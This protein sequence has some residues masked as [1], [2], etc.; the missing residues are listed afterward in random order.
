MKTSIGIILEAVPSS[1]SLDLLTKDLQGINGV[2][3]V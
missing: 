2:R 3:W 1:V